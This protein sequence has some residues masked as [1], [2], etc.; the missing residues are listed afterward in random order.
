MDE[1]DPRNEPVKAWCER[2]ELHVRIKDGR[3]LSAPLWWYPR[4][5][6]ATPAQRENF[7][8][9]FIGIHWPD[10]DEDIS[11]RG[12]LLGAKAP[13]AVEPEDEPA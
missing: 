8:L 10:V 1:L 12:L 5:L 13:N 4:L 7:E 3:T 2:D 11:V 6:K 9:S